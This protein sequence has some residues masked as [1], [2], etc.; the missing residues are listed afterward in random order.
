METYLFLRAVEGL[1]PGI[2]HFRPHVFD[3]EFLKK[4]NSSRE[5]AEA[6][7]G[8]MIVMGTQVTFI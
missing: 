4:V 7:L 2:Y 1:E 6:V 8:Q 5:L 3:L